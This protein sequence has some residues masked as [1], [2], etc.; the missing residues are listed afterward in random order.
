LERVVSAVAAALIS[1]CANK[2][3]RPPRRLSPSKF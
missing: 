2:S 3:R 1:K